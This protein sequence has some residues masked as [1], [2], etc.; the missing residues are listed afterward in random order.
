MAVCTKVHRSKLHHYTPDDDAMIRRYY[1]SKDM[2]N[3]A[4][5]QKLG[6][7]GPALKYHASCLG[8]TRRNIL[9][10]FRRFDEQDDNTI[11]QMVGEYT[12]G[13][14]AERLKRS[15]QSI[16]DR[17]SYLGLRCSAESRD[18]WY[19]CSDVAMIL[20]MNDTTVRNIIK[21]GMI[22]ARTHWGKETAY[23]GGR[24]CWHISR[25]ALRE[26][27]CTYPTVLNGR[28]VDFVQL[29]DVLAEVKAQ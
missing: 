8:L 7:T 27:I 29:V 20:G 18:G 13:S 22:K 25:E 28:T 23:G 26:F 9:R 19:T 3:S 5:A 24:E 12:I 14:I 4:L 2:T 17:M 11:H 6:V 21:R 10:R 1:N 16:L 15:P